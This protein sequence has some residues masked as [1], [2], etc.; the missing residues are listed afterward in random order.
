MQKQ[1][2]QNTQTAFYSPQPGMCSTQPLRAI[3]S[4]G[5]YGPRN[6]QNFLIDSYTT[7]H[8]DQDSDRLMGSSLR[9]NLLKDNHQ[10]IEKKISALKSN[11]L[12]SRMSSDNFQFASKPLE[13]L[14]RRM[15]DTGTH[16]T[17]QIRAD[18]LLTEILQE[19]SFISTNAKKLQNQRSS[20]KL[21][22][23]V[24]KDIREVV[25]GWNN[26]QQLINQICQSAQISIHQLQNTNISQLFK[27]DELNKLY[28]LVEKHQNSYP[29][30][31]EQLYQII[32]NTFQS[33]DLD[34]NKLI[35]INTQ[36]RQQ[37]IQNKDLNTKNKNLFAV[38]TKLEAKVNKLQ[39]K[40][41]QLELSNKQISN[42]YQSTY[43]PYDTYSENDKF[44][45]KNPLVESQSS[46]DS[47]N[48]QHK[49]L[50]NQL[51][52]F[53]ELI[54]EKES[55]ISNL[56]QQIDDEHELIQD[57]QKKVKQLENEN[58]LLKL[59]L[60]KMVESEKQLQKQKSEVNS[61]YQHYKDDSSQKLK[62]LSQEIVDLK[63]KQNK[64]GLRDCN[65]EVEQLNQQISKLKSEKEEKERENG[66][67]Q[68]KL[69]EM[70][71]KY[72]DL[73]QSYQELS[74]QYQRDQQMNKQIVQSLQTQK[75]DFDNR[76]S[77]QQSLFHLDL[78]SQQELETQQQLIKQLE[79]D[80]HQAQFAYKQQETKLLDY[81]DEINN[82]KTQ[83]MRLEEE[84]TEQLHILDNTIQSK[85]QII[86]QYE[87]NS[88]ILNDTPEQLRSKSVE[89]TTIQGHLKSQIDS[90]NKSLSNFEQQ[91]RDLTKVNNEYQD[92][93]NNKDKI[94]KQ[95]TQ[96]VIQLQQQL[97]DLQG[98]NQ[99]IQV[100][101]RAI[102]H[103]EK[104]V[105]T[106]NQTIQ[107]LQESLNFKDQI[108]LGKQ[109][110][111][112]MLLNQKKD[113]IQQQ[114]QQSL[115]FEQQH[116]KAKVEHQE[117]QN[118]VKQL[119]EQ[120]IAKQKDEITINV[121]E[122]ILQNQIQQLEQQMRKHKQDSEDEKK[123][124]NDKI[125]RL[126]L[127][128]D[129]AEKI[130]ISL[131]EKQISLENAQNKV[132]ELESELISSQDQI[133]Q[134]ES[135]ILE[136]QKEIKLERSNFLKE[137]QLKIE[138][139]N[140][141]HQEN[142]EL[143]QINQDLTQKNM[144]LLEEIE[145]L[146]SGQRKIQLNLNQEIQN[147]R[148]TENQNKEIIKKHHLQISELNSQISLFNQKQ[149]LAN[150][151]KA[152]LSEMLNQQLHTITELNKQLELRNLQNDQQ[153]E[154]NKAQFSTE[155]VFREAELCRNLI[156]QSQETHK[157]LIQIG[158]LI[159]Q[160]E[161]SKLTIK[162]QEKQLLDQEQK[163][164]ILQEESKTQQ[165]IQNQ[166]EELNSLTQTQ[167]LTI[168]NLQNEL[169]EK[170][171]K[172]QTQMLHAETQEQE[173][174]YSQMLIDDLNQQLNNFK[175]LNEE[176]KQQ[177]QSLTQKSQSNQQQI[178]NL[179][180]KIKDL[181][182][183]KLI[184]E[185]KI[186]ETTL[187]LKQ[188]QEKCVKLRNDLT[189]KSNQLNSQ[190]IEIKQIQNENSHF[191]QFNNDLQKNLEAREI[192]I[193]NNTNIINDLDKTI[194]QKNEELKEKSN[195]ILE[196]I[197][198]IEKSNSKLLQ[199]QQQNAMLE[200]QTQQRIQI[201]QQI[202][203]EINQL[204]HSNHEL[205]Q[206][207]KKLQLQIN[208]DAQNYNQ[209]NQRNIELQE[210]NTTLN[211]EILD[212]KK[213]NKD[214]VENQVQIT[215]KN[216]ADQAQNR[217]IGSLQE[218]I[219]N[220]EQKISQLEND[221]KIKEDQ[222]IHSIQENQA[223]EQKLLQQ[224]NQLSQDHGELMALQKIDYDKI[225]QQ[226]NQLQLQTNSQQQDIQRLQLE[227]QQ[228]I[229]SKQQINNQKIELEQ[230][231]ALLN[232]SFSQKEQQNQQLDQQLKDS[233]SFLQIEQNKLNSQIENL[234]STISVLRKQLDQQQEIIQLKENE[235][236]EY[237]RRE[238]ETLKLFE[239]KNEEILQ[240][241]T[242]LDLTQQNSKEIQNP[243]K[244]IDAL[245][246]KKDSEISEL[247]N[248]I[249][250]K[251]IQIDKIVADSNQ[252][253]FLLQEIKSLFNQD[254]I[255]DY[256]RQFKSQHEKQCER[257]FTYYQCLQ[258][259]M[260]EL[261]RN[262]QAAFYA[263]NYHKL[264]Q[265]EQNN[266]LAYQKDI[267]LMKAKLPV[268]TALS[269]I[270]EEKNEDISFSSNGQ[271]PEIN[272]NDI[273][274]FIGDLDISVIVNNDKNK[275]E[276]STSNKQQLSHTEEVNIL[277]SKLEAAN[278]EN[279]KI[280]AKFQ[281][282]LERI[283]A[284]EEQMLQLNNL[285]RDYKHK[286][287]AMQKTSV[288]PQAVHAKAHLRDCLKKFLTACGPK[289]LNYDLAEA[290]LNTLFQ[291]LEF[292]EKEKEEILDELAVKPADKKKGIVQILFKK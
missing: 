241:K 187:L 143:V 166:I 41:Q 281:I 71:S 27:R 231:L 124:L 249:Q 132:S 285:A 198:E 95:K 205:E 1:S 181:E 116:Q 142:E 183:T 272:E 46:L 135:R 60:S 4:P 290:I 105:Q 242:Q 6:S 119:E 273:S 243:Q 100:Q 109:H 103:H 271:Q 65:S 191:K 209:L 173:V 214:L 151:D 13:K 274:D 280:I 171:L 59:Q 185:F 179:E 7:K 161:K 208:Q 283:A 127:E 270:K 30:S 101:D 106:L 133:Q 167:N 239:Q 99:K 157:L 265:Q 18:D 147:L 156:I 90:L 223:Q 92:Q 31:F 230:K 87:S 244:E 138:E 104:Q 197:K 218:Q 215:N 86:Q 136:L 228:E 128:L 216:E 245:I 39:N 40:K 221:L 168:S 62:S 55:E 234:N 188:E 73:K 34:H 220:L 203:Q 78:V 278:E 20:Q 237:S 21:Q 121:Q 77:G 207:N 54:A 16:K 97:K 50:E 212:L 43:R 284:K 11:L 154:E 23:K 186:N 137:N 202:Q 289:N 64:L 79:S 68:I 287:M 140:S 32:A 172:L 258:S 177:I 204:Q 252:N 82:L 9:F 126:N 276:H 282:L 22:M 75:E 210:R 255:L 25:T 130:Q 44:K 96:E 141:Q 288:D 229:E 254:N 152:K 28:S 74:D 14:L 88:R 190:V 24:L 236:A 199:L 112:E 259:L 222:I 84:H 233:E 240:L 45:L 224:N 174:R 235:L 256:L 178:Q 170:N 66:Q 182:Q 189:E 17:E 123:Q 201:N 10:Q 98:L 93:I 94:L 213:N 52:Q 194:N 69:Q 85:D 110:E 5:I 37:E 200:N 113:H 162:E 266:L 226:N 61:E 70:K 111:I 262:Q 277:K 117:L 225:K 83:I 149:E 169:N 268:K 72:N 125:Q 251:Q 275:K 160:L 146:Q 263:Q 250:A 49:L 57:H 163:Y 158:T 247:Q 264:S 286:M 134:L 291:F 145:Q 47:K 217:L 114:K 120:I 206:N 193:A 56:K 246:A 269:N 196:Q 48:T 219:N 267:Q 19:L 292:T 150:Q 195:K 253:Q 248:V 227:L 3:I 26:M 67:N 211:N 2:R 38:I 176:Y 89:Q 238:S 36:L 129:E 155:L 58:K 139:L 192:I 144:Q 15:D 122:E 180:N 131:N 33:R 108:L 260:D 175:I 165:L 51:T 29:Q 153:I 76:N 12:Q 159:E 107:K 35:E 8:Q 184:Q 102:H 164:I 63:Q 232:Q 115:L 279:V 118:K 42:Q 257:K 261:L 80:L 81:E 53:Q 91:I 148:A